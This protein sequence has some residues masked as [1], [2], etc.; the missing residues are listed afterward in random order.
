MSAPIGS[1]SPHPES[2]S[3]ASHAGEKPYSCG[4]CTTQWSGWGRAHCSGCHRTFNTTNLFDRHRR[5]HGEH[6]FCLDPATIDSKDG[7]LRFISGVWC[8]PELP[9]E[10]L[11]K[12]RRS[13]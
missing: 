13:R 6:G 7:P 3:R 11:A 4:R 9:P 5:L 2:R 12:I 1:P 10:T 8:G